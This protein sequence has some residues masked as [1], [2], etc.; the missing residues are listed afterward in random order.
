MENKYSIY[1]EVSNLRQL[2]LASAKLHSE[3]IAFQYRDGDE[4]VRK[5][6]SLFC[7]DVASFGTALL[8][9]GYG[10]GKHIVIFSENNYEFIVVAFAIISSASTFIPVDK[11]VTAEGLYS[12]LNYADCDMLIYSDTYH[13][14]V[15]TLI[16][17][18]SNTTFVNMQCKRSGAISFSDLII[19]GS[20]YLSHGDTI[21]FDCSLDNQST[22]AIF[23]TSG[24]TGNIKGAMHTH[25][26]LT[27]YVKSM[28][29]TI[30]FGLESIL[31]LPLYHAAGFIGVLLYQVARGGTMTLPKSVRY[32]S[33]DLLCFRPTYL[34]VVP[35]IIEMLYIRVLEKI[36]SSRKERMYQWMMKLSTILLFVGIDLRNFFFKD[37]R[38]T[39]GGKLKIIGTGGAPLDK[40]YIEAFCSIGIDIITAYGLTECA[41]F[42]TCNQPAY[43]RESSLGTVLPSFQIMIDKDT[44]SD[45]GEILVRGAPVMSG[46]YK[47]PDTNEV[48]FTDGW[49]HTGDIGRLSTDGYLYVT[50]RIRNIIKGSN[51]KNIYPE[52]L[53][54]LLSSISYIQE[55]VVYNNQVVVNGV[56]EIVA[57]IFPNME[58]FDASDEDS[59]R[60][61]LQQEIDRVNRTLPLYKRIHHYEIRTSAFVK[62][63]STKIIRNGHNAQ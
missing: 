43:Y 22:A 37:I 20:S 3:S 17:P 62:T 9:R 54:V 61:I 31:L 11:E 12:A 23:F 16:N 13:D 46:Y 32:L 63:G 10:S 58:M 51:G 28:L 39:L 33:E 60:T 45:E 38:A 40:R 41:C 56:V 36:K 14:L 47:N 53:E 49:F 35:L 7:H 30:D 27:A 48:I 19:Q 6:F 34:V 44:D 50:G 42:V 21:F 4:M 52:E 25:A 2:L 18:A 29:E 59:I 1:N 5:S 15:E 55:A 8:K 26:G 24:T 57:E